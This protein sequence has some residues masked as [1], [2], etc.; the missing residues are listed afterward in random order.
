MQSTLEA[1]LADKV[2]ATE[3]ASAATEA[4]LHVEFE[5]TLATERAAV[6]CKLSDMTLHLEALQAVLSHDTHYKQTSHATHQLSAA[7]L[8]IEESMTRRS[9][10]PS[11][12]V[13]G[14][15][16]ALAAALSDELLVEATR[17]L[18]GKGAERLSEVRQ[19]AVKSPL[20]AS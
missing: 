10:V 19:V 6:G 9:T 5:D 11:P 3:Q 4:R 20:R 8:A 18:A 13:L 12:K 2:Q 7:V 1:A 14:A 17:P 16:P 15:L